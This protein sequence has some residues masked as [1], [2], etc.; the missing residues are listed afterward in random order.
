MVSKSTTLNDKPTTLPADI[1]F[2]SISFS[3]VDY[4]TLGLAKAS[5]DSVIYLKKKTIY[6][7]EVVVGPDN[8]KSVILGEN[9]RFVKRYSKPIHKNL[10]DGIVIANGSPQKLQ[11]NKLAFYVEKVKFKTAYKI[12]FT[13]VREVSASE[14]HE[15]AELGGS[16]FTSDTLYLEPKAKGKVEVSLPVDFYLPATKKMF[17]WIQLIRYSDDLG[18]EAVPDIDKQTKLK[19]QMSNKMNYYTKMTDLHT[20]EISKDMININ[21]MI[22][23]DFATMFFDTPHKSSLITPAIVLYAQKAD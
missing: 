22:N 15:F 17:V 20:R 19:F 10:V 14:G 16:I 5:I 11:L 13:E 4:E 2:D 18:N 7:D 9:N 8:K 21:R 23:Y 12:N 6:L 1:D 3:R